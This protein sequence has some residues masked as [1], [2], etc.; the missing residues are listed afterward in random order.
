[1]ARVRRLDPPAQRL[2]RAASL[3]AEDFELTVVGPDRWTCRRQAV[4]PPRARRCPRACWST[5]AA[6]GSGSPT[7]WCARCWQPRHRCSRPSSAHPGR[8]GARGPAQRRAG[9]GVG[10][11]RAALDGGVRSPASA[12]RRSD[13]ARRAAADAAHALAYEEASRLYASALTHGGA[14]LAAGE[15]ADLLLAQ[16][17]ADVAAGRFAD[18]FA[19]VPPGGG[20]GRGAGR[21]DLVA[22]AALTLDAVGDRDLGPDRA[23]LVP[24]RARRP[25]RRRCRAAAGCWPGWRRPASTAATSRVR[26]LPRR[27]RWRSP[28]PAL[29][30]MRWSPALRARQLTYSGPEH[31]D[32]R[33]DLARSHDGARRAGTQAR[34]GDVGHGCG[35][36][37]CCGSAVTS[38][39]SRPRST[40]LRWCVEQQRS[41]LAGW[42]LLV[43]RAAL[44]QARGELAQ[45]LALGDE[46]FAL[47]GG[48]RAPRGV[49]RAAVA[50]RGDRPP[51]RARGGRVRAARR[52][53]DGRRAGPGEPVRA[54]GPR[55]RARR[56]R[57]ARRGR[58][59]LPAHRTTAELG[60]PAVLHGARAGRRRLHRDPPRPAAT[61]SPGSAPRWRA[62][63]PATSW[64]AGARRTT[65][66]RSRSCSA[67]ARRPSTTSTPPRT[68]LGV[69]PGDLRTHRRPRVRGGG[70]VSSSPRCGC[71]SA[72][73]T[74]PARCCPAPGPPPSAWA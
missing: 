17:G 60:H 67:G 3:L 37:T 38:A 13:W 9:A 35:P 65:S 7:A 46:A 27:A 64:A 14:T 11:H 36:S 30:R 71:G 25:R 51:R 43:C 68:V 56:E 1:M 61:T 57:Q 24:P 54:A 59:P 39:G 34:G 44:A 72:S 45:A 70:R 5:A 16:A 66:A 69:R 41:P 74:R 15:R 19:S 48:H 47:V 32:E 55:R 58:P 28:S 20:A 63:G 49:R 12:D 2:L 52:S 26:T 40:R 22:A 53:R 6:A 33:A 10:R 4:C 18:A 29:T 50:A 31:S 8:A 73:R 21:T 62:T 23:E 42:H